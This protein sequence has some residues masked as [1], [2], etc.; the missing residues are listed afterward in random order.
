MELKLFSLSAIGKIHSPA[1]PGPKLPGPNPPGPPPGPTPPGP[2]PPGP[3][4][5]TPPEEQS[6]SK[7]KTIHDSVDGSRPDIVT[8]SRTKAKHCSQTRSWICVLFHEVEIN[9]RNSLDL[10]HRNTVLQ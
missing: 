10:R 6:K 7:L 4:P 9:M 8:E 1:L 5:P 2:T 3:C